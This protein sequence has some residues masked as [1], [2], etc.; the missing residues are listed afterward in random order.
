MTK[1]EIAPLDDATRPKA[2]KIDGVTPE[3]RRQGRGLRLIHDYHLEHMNE[4]SRLMDEIAAGEQSAATLRDA[5]ASMPMLENYRLFSN[6]CGR[7]CHLLSLHHMI[8]NES[9]FPY[10]RDAGGEGLRKVIDRLGQEHD[11]IHELL[12]A[13]HAG[14][15]HA[16]QQPGH[17]TFADL[18]DA[19]LALDR[20]VR[21][22]FGYEQE[23]L[24]EALGYYDVPV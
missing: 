21:S 24:E 11:V 20:V 6:L 4:V 9:M 17:E 15:V 18:K 23:E 2:P 19:F 22:H 5:I 12:L 8:E 1:S 13:L 16:A 10:L 3:Q 7:E 14:A